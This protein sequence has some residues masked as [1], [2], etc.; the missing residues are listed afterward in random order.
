MAR[1]LHGVHGKDRIH[2]L[3]QVQTEAKLRR[4]EDSYD[5]EQSKDEKG[6]VPQLWYDLQQVPFEQVVIE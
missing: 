3:R 1:T 2:V 5:Q 6:N 4:S